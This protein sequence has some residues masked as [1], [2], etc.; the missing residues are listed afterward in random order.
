[1]AKSFEFMTKV[2]VQVAIA[3]SLAASAAAAPNIV[4]VIADD[5]G[6]GDVGFHGSE[7]RTPELDRLAAG[8]VR[9][10][11]FYT[12]ALCSPTRAALMTGRSGIN[13]GMLGP[14]NPWYPRGL[15]VDEKLMP[16]YFR[17]AGY[18]T[19][20][21]G[22]WHLGPNEPQYH[23]MKH[24][25][26]SFYGHLHGYLNHELHTLFGRV[27]WQR[28]GK[29]VHET[30][31]ATQLVIAEAVR[32]IEER[33][34]DAPFLLHVALDAPHAP[35][36]APE[37]AI[38]EYAHVD[39]ERRR[40]YSAMMTDMDRGIAR[41]TAALEE[42]GIAEN[43]LLIFFSD[44]GGSP[45]LGADNGPLR[46]GKGS[47]FEGGTRA[48]AFM[49]WPTVLPAGALFEE[50]M[51]VTD[52]LPTLLAAADAD[53]N[54][55]KPIDGRDFWPAI[56]D[57]AQAPGGPAVLSH[58]GRGVIQHAY[59][60]DDWKLVRAA[61]DQGG[62]DDLLFDIRK[63]PY[64]QHDLAAAHPDVFRQL[65]EELDAIPKAEP[66]SLNARLPDMTAPGSPMAWEPDNRPP[67][68]TPYAESGPVPYP[69]GNYP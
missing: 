36:Q 60:R 68:G 17:E 66:L 9:F 1:M 11:R 10:E 50:R 3:A 39:D 69:E 53:L 38:A 40:I 63:D 14:S 51:I 44:N 42:A 7:I 59:F 16:E 28:D 24:G 58:Y 15:P 32:Q 35:L 19:H 23:P 45:N 25:F 47:P 55:S 12:Y 18:R 57:G 31:H 62:T 6:W 52:L 26:E 49:Y 67:G 48:P 37:D 20:A 4:I 61:N 65:V 54:A 34:P 5:M 33:D 13:T 56:A 46:G 30:G 22:K 2:L 8:G 43:T 27:D 21:L 64:E 29:T 41:I